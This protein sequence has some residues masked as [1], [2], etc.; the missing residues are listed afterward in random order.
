M[1]R[2]YLEDVRRMALGD[3]CIGRGANQRNL[4]RSSLLQRLEGAAVRTG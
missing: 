4:R 3:C 1:V 2:G